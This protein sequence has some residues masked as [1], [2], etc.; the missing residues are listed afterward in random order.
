MEGTAGVC[1]AGAS[2]RHNLRVFL[3]VA[4]RTEETTA[5]ETPVKQRFGSLWGLKKESRSKIRNS[6]PES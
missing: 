3:Q 4:A 1:L 5:A 2:G 6:K